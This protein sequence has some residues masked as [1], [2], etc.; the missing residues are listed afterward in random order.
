MSAAVLAMIAVTTSA[1]HFWLLAPLL[2]AAQAATTYEAAFSTLT[3]HSGERA[4]ATISR[5]TLFGGL[6]SSVFWPVTSF[7]LAHL[8]WREVCLIFAAFRRGKATCAM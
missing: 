4:R 8:D 5:V 2:G 7:L 6:A 3:Q 1:A